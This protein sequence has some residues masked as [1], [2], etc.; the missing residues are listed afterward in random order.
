[1]IRSVS[2][3]ACGTLERVTDGIE[4][5][6]CVEIR[7]RSGVHMTLHVERLADR[8]A[9][10][11]FVLAHRHIG[12]EPVPD[13]EVTMLRGSDGHWTPLAIA[14]PFSSL[15]TAST[16]GS[17]MATRRNE[18]RRLITLVEVWMTN[19]RTNL[20][21]AGA[22]ENEEIRGPVVYAAE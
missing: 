20:L 13:P 21:K 6:E 10:S 2:P 5:G 3:S 19:V 14:L 16:D 4:A 15:T 12:R 1:M 11:V 9:G 8:P 18:H 7:D 22:P 17:V